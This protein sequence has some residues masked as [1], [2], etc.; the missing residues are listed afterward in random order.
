[1]KT[2]RFLALPAIAAASMLA[3]TG[4]IQLPPVVGSSTGSQAPAGEVE[5]LAGSSWSGSMPGIAD[6][7]GFTLADDGTIDIT[8]WGDS[9]QTYDSSA[10]VW[11]GDTG[12]LEMTITGLENDTFDVTL[13]GT[14]ADGQMQLSG[15]GTNGTSYTLN[16]TQG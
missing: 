11:S 13:T 12:D 16:A 1:M 10:D 5:E 15:E 3:L 14:A 6:P 7:F 2:T 8:V 9:G 4:C